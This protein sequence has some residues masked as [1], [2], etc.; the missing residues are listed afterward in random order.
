MQLRLG[1][2]GSTVRIYTSR[3]AH[4]ITVEV[5]GRSRK[6]FQTE[7][8]KLVEFPVYESAEAHMASIP[9]ENGEPMFSAE[10]IEKAEAWIESQMQEIDAAY[11]LNQSLG[12][13][14]G[15][16]VI[17]R[18]SSDDQ[19]YCSDPGFIPG[20][21]VGEFLGVIRGAHDY[22][23]KMRKKIKIP[24][25]EVAEPDTAAKAWNEGRFEDIEN[26]NIMRI[27]M[28]AKERGKPLDEAFTDEEID[29]F[30]IASRQLFYAITRPSYIGKAQNT[31]NDRLRKPSEKK[32]R[33]LMKQPL[34]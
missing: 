6:I 7:T 12:L 29:Q 28:I 5:K 13:M 10:D 16:P 18:A 31:M 34:A 21:K 15:V 2:D 20:R 27:R 1:K 17:K 14:G 24:Q 11:R 25:V 9:K 23:P 26:E 22:K 3:A 4:F 33:D 30:F 8:T 19:K 32:L